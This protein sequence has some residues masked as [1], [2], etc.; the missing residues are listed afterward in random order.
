MQGKALDELKNGNVHRFLEHRLL[1][2]I[3]H[4]FGTNLSDY[5]YWKSRLSNAIGVDSKAILIIG[6]S[7]L[8]FSINPNKN[9][10]SFDDGSDIDIAIISQYFFDVS[11]RHIRNLK[12]SEYHSYSGLIQASLRDHTER[13]IYWGTIATDKI[14]PI[15]PFKMEWSDAANLMRTIAPTT[16]RDINFR[17]YKDFESLRAYQIY[18]LKKLQLKLQEAGNV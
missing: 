7:C 12:S 1:E 16:D 10:K 9:F 13:L 4:V 8:G 11:W 14:L 17:I 6:S 2:T 18:G 15:L 5:L 3:P